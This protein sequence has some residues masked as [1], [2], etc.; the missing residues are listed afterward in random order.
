MCDCLINDEFVKFGSI[1][2]DYIIM[3]LKWCNSDQLWVCKD[4]SH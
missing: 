4:Y 3:L 2:C 1:M